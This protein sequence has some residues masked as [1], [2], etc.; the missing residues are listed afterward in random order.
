MPAQV[1]ALGIITAEEAQQL[2]PLIAARVP[3]MTCGTTGSGRSKL[4]E[5]VRSQAGDAY[6]Y[7]SNGGWGEPSDDFRDILVRSPRI[8]DEFFAWYVHEA[9]PLGKG[10]AFD[11]QLLPH[12]DVQ[13]SLSE[14]LAAL[15]R[16][17][18]DHNLTG[19]ALYVAEGHLLK[20]VPFRGTKTGL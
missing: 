12:E 13:E 8:V 20:T 15:G 18:P 5:W 11:W 10:L 7:P 6:V 16:H 1:I 17:M 3:I 14:V 2:L 9:Q 4:F 19:V